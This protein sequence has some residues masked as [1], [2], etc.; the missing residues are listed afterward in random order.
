MK[1]SMS[2][3]EQFLMFI[4][5]VFGFLALM[6]T[7]ILSPLLTNQKTL[8]S[9]YDNLNTQKMIIDT[10]VPNLPTLEKN[11]E[12]RVLEVSNIL[13]VFEAPLHSAQFENRILSL[14]TDYDMRVVAGQFSDPAVL[15][16]LA[17]ETLPLELQ[18]TLGDLVAQYKDEVIQEEEIPASLA[19]VYKSTQSFTVK[20][21]YANFVYFLDAIKKW[22]TSIIIAE[23]S[24]IFADSE[25]QYTFD[26]YFVDQLLM[27]EMT[28]ITEDIIANGQG[29]ANS[30][31]DPFASSK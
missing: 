1:V 26:V 28:V 16:P 14:M 30:N 27:D 21:S 8:Q 17:L 15:T 22:D 7:F 19:M 29:S 4:L 23:A 18:T 6:Y 13:E 31:V 20:T 3:R 10:Q 5:I 11:L 12:T 2:K 25:A 24:Y 9:E